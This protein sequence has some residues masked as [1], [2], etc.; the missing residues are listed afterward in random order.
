[1]EGKVSK[2]TAERLVPSLYLEEIFSLPLVIVIGPSGVQ[3]R[4]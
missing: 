3:F 1:M 2:V 4:E